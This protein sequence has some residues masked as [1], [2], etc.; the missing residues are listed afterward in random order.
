MLEN[1]TLLYIKKKGHFKNIFGKN[2]QNNEDWRETKRFYKMSLPVMSGSFKAVRP[3][4]IKKLDTIISGIE[5]LNSTKLPN[6]K[7]PVIAPM[8]IAAACTPM[9]VDLQR[10][11]KLS[12]QINQVQSQ[13]E[14]YQR[15]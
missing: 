10:K 3:P 11:K 9:P 1:G 4:N 8:R 7:L 15:L 12:H 13:V 5:Q 14:S 2:K 6:T